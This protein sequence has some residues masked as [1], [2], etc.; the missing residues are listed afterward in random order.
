MR[1]RKGKTLKPGRISHEEAE[2]IDVKGLSLGQP[3][4]RTCGRGGAPKRGRAS[5]DAAEVR[6]GRP[7]RAFSHKVRRDQL[8][9]DKGHVSLRSGPEGYRFSI[10]VGA[11]ISMGPRTKSSRQRPVEEASALF[12]GAL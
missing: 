6:R 7:E 4:R 5:A 8:S 10:D 9:L 1:L 3:N 11:G 2:K 12:W